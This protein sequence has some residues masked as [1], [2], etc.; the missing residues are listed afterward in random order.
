MFDKNSMMK[1]E[2]KTDFNGEKEVSKGKYIYS[3]FIRRKISV[4]LYYDLQKS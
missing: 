2:K 1:N 3:H 4:K